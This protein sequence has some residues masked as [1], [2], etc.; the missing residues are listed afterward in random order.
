MGTQASLEVHVNSN[1]DTTGHPKPAQQWTEKRHQQGQETKL[2]SQETR[3]GRAQDS[4][5]GIRVG[6]QGHAQKTEMESKMSKQQDIKEHVKETKENVEHVQYAEDVEENKLENPQNVTVTYKTMSALDQVLGHEEI[7]QQLRNALAV[8]ETARRL[9]LNSFHVRRGMLLVGRPGTGKSMIAKA[10]AK[11]CKRHLVAVSA[12]SLS[13]EARHGSDMATQV[14]LCFE[15]ARKH[16]PSIIFID[17]IDLLLSPFHNYVLAELLTQLDGLDSVDKDDVFV[18]AATN[19]LEEIP[20]ALTRSG[21]LNPILQLGLPDQKVRVDMYQNFIQDENIDS[22]QINFVEAAKLSAG[23]TGADIKGVCI[24][25][26]TH[27][28]VRISD[29]QQVA[30]LLKLEMNDILDAIDQVHLGLPI[31]KTMSEQEQLRAAAHEGGHAVA[32][33]TLFGFGSILKVTIVPHTKFQG[34]VLSTSLEDESQTYD[35]LEGR[36][37]SC[38]AGM[39]GEKRKLGQYSLGSERDVKSAQQL[40]GQMKMAGMLPWWKGHDPVEEREQSSTTEK[41][42]AYLCSLALRAESLVE[43]HADLHEKLISALMSKKTLS[44]IEIA[45]VLKT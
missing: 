36:I 13:K 23:F 41:L 45:E 21:R 28:L 22:S 26:V 18:L 15:N 1:R 30:P 43:A 35:Y 32:M 2:P 16:W 6:K 24:D 7:K 33:I 20:E 11:E 37:I 39:E 10:I 34:V 9:K 5:V 38:Y 44:Q 17:E 8:T 31:H 27:A 3:Q 40:V 14:R 19:T 4:L 25:A 12:A 29:T 42:M